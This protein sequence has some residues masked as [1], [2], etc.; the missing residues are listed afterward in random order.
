MSSWSKTAVATAQSRRA[1]PEAGARRC[2]YNRPGRCCGY[3]DFLPVCL[4]DDEIVR[5][6]LVQVAPR[7]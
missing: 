3:C 4:G 2:F 6:T 5:E 7:T 1:P